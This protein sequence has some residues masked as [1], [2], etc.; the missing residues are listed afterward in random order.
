MSSAVPPERR[1]ARPQVVFLFLSA[2]T[3][4]HPVV[5]PP[6]MALSVSFSTPPLL[7]VF[8]PSLRLRN[9]PHPL[10]A[11]LCHDGKSFHSFRPLF[12]LRLC[13]S[14]VFSS[15]ARSAWTRVKLNSWKSNYVACKSDVSPKTLM[16][17]LLSM[18]SLP[19][20]VCQSLH[21]LTTL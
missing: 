21:Y 1:R 13:Q 12:S 19:L 16:F 3:L 14:E 4:N 7:S 20:G 15:P 11:P 5:F 17:L 18:S 2:F 6:F 10:L 8:F 9:L